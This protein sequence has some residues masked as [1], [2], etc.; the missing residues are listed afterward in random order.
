MRIV[1]NCAQQVTGDGT[2]L[3]QQ[4]ALLEYPQGSSLPWRAT[5][6]DQ[7]PRNELMPGAGVCSA[8]ERF[9]CGGGRSARKRLGRAAKNCC[10]TGCAANCWSIPSCRRTNSGR[11]LGGEPGLSVQTS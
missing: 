6:G 5:I 10:I 4:G 8:S 7:Q 1:R 3:R 2:C 9:I 11:R